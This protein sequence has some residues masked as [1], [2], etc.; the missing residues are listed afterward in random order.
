MRKKLEISIPYVARKT[1]LY[2]S[3]FSFIER[4][5]RGY[6]IVLCRKP[7]NRTTKRQGASR[8][9][10]LFGPSEQQV[11]AT[12]SSN[13]AGAG[14]LME[15]QAPRFNPRNQCKS[16]TV[17][18]GVRA[19]KEADRRKRSASTIARR[20]SRTKTFTGCLTQGDPREEEVVTNPFVYNRRKPSARPQHSSGPPARHG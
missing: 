8:P 3:I 4:R 9:P 20:S 11:C 16:V 19:T 18:R 2:T 14:P 17:S 7:K 5:K 1:T 12:P 15:F 10:D 13:S 6:V